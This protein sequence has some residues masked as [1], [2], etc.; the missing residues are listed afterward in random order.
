ML[1]HSLK[2]ANYCGVVQVHVRA[3]MALNKLIDSAR[4]EVR[5]V[6]SQRAVLFGSSENYLICL[7]EVT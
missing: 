6:D 5:L 4:V 7:E 1:D 2:V 3:T